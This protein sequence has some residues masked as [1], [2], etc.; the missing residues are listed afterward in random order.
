M[1]VELEAKAHHRRFVMA[2]K[3]P[4]IALLLDVVKSGPMF[5]GVR[6]VVDEGEGRFRFDLEPRR[7]LGVSFH[8]Q[9]LTQYRREGDSVHW[10]TVSGNL[11][12]TGEWIV[13]E[14]AGRIEI[15]VKVLTKVEAPVPR[16]LK[17]PAQ[18]F[19][20][21]ELRDGMKVQLQN[22]QKSLEQDAQAA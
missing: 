17:K 15:E 18:L 6:S 4:A 1:G 14:K 11:D 20:D 13:S 16:I 21:L 8:G 19:A 5:P 10:S 3:E 7:T 2:D 9:Y 12:V 22:L